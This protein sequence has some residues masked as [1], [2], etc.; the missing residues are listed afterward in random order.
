MKLPHMELV[1][2]SNVAAIGYEDDTRCLFVR[3]NDGGLYRYEGVSLETYQAFMSAPS[4]GRFVWR[5]LRGKYPY[6]RIG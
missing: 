5:Q 3:F 6:S 4:K 2:S 1:T